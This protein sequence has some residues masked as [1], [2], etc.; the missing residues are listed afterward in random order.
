M[1]IATAWTCTLTPAPIATALA[2]THYIHQSDHQSCV[3]WTANDVP[4]E[5]SNSIVSNR[6]ID[7]V[8]K[9]NNK[10][11]S[12]WIHSMTCVTTAG[13]RNISNFYLSERRKH[14]SIWRVDVKNISSHTLFNWVMNDLEAQSV[15]QVGNTKW[16]RIA[17]SRDLKV[18]SEP[19]MY[20]CVRCNFVDEKKSPRQPLFITVFSLSLFSTELDYAVSTIRCAVPKLMS[21]NDKLD[22]YVISKL[23]YLLCSFWP[24]AIL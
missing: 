18:E 9:N 4:I 15:R 2:Q 23:L 3:K 20:L 1:W 13:V 6:R 24:L 17:L 10:Q 12:I 14:T 8:N 16:I 19:I 7:G 11:K 5:K 21:W 22:R